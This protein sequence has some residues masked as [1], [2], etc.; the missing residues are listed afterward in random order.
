MNDN[1]PLVS[2][3]TPSYNQASYLEDTIRSVLA[4]DYPHLEY[5]LVDGGSTD[6]SLEIIQRYA[7]DFAWWVTEPDHGQAEAINKGLQRAKGKIV[8]WI[9]SDDLYLPGAVSQAVEVLNSRPDL[10][11]VFGDAL[12]IDAEGHP[13]N[14]LSFGDWGLSEL[15]RFR[16]ICQP[17]VFLRREAVQQVGLLDE[18]FH[19]ML[20]HQL[21]LRI[22]IQWPI[23]HVAQLWA[24]ARHHPQA[25]NA[26]QGAGFSRETLQ[27]LGWMQSAPDL[28]NRFQHDHSHIAGGAYRLSARYLLD[29]GEFEAALNEYGRALVN[30][31][32]YTLKHWHRILYAAL[33]LV[34]L[35]HLDHWYYRLNSPPNLAAYP[36]LKNWP[37]LALYP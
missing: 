27:L 2:I 18:N 6:G 8:A 23:Q 1:L 36:Q 37:G 35:K 26:A 34:G 17:S 10:G 5:L 20:D 21:W 31:P 19:F 7:A 13:L 9:N 32:G 24:A 25:K 33:S 12:T 4:Q 28:A 30:W 22:A 11:M 3:I 14:I 16:I 15:M 29:G